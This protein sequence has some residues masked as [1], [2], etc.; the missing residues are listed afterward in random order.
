MYN[1][2][3]YS[4]QQF[5]ATTIHDITGLKIGQVSPFQIL[6]FVIHVNLAAM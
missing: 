2:I 6:Q 3:V 5:T 4:R 1:R